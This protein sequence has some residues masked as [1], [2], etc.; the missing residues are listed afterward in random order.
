MYFLQSILNYKELSLS[1]IVIFSVIIYKI[2]ESRNKRL[3]NFGPELLKRLNESD[4][5]P[6]EIAR[7]LAREKKLK[8]SPNLFVTNKEDKKKEFHVF[9]SGYIEKEY[10]YVQDSTGWKKIDL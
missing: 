7:Q 9:I 5:H 8:C 1:V 6:S 2:R 3:I 4:L 10:Q